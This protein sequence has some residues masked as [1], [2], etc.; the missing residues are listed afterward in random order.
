VD[1][2]IA[3]AVLN[4]ADDL[5]EEVARL[6]LPQPALA[7]DT[8]YSCFLVAKRTHLLHNVVEELACFDVFHHLELVSVVL[9]ARFV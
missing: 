2:H 9:S 1:H 3:V 5:L 6:V 7:R 8:R 4:A